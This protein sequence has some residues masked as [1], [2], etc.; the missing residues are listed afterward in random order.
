[1]ED[2]LRTAQCH[3]AL[4]GIR[5]TLRLKTHMV[6]FKNKNSRGQREGLRSRTLI[7][8]IQGRVKTLA[9][10]YRAA[11]KAKMA[12][13]ASGDWMNELQELLDKHLRSYTDPDL[14]ANKKRK[15]GVAVGDDDDGDE[16]EEASG[17]P[18]RRPAGESRRIISWI[19]QVIPVGAGVGGDD[20]DESR[21]ILFSDVLHVTDM[22]YPVQ[23]CDAN[24]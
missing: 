14:E 12:L 9:E 22:C 15:A 19:W 10:K 4:H 18:K 23:Y 8:R 5:N 13:V 7:D 3:D 21:S 16:V 6:Y 11:R 1:M 20:M 17:I 2:R 24:G